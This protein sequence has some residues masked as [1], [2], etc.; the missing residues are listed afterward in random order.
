MALAEPMAFTTGLPMRSRTL[1]AL[2]TISG[3]RGLVTTEAPP[4]EE[5]LQ[6]VRVQIKELL[7]L[8]VGWDSSVA[9]AIS[10]DAVETAINCLALVAEAVGGLR[11]PYVSPTANGGVNIEW[12]DPDAHFD[13][14]VEDGQVHVFA[15]APGV[16]WE[17]A[18]R[19][20][21]T[22]AIGVLFSRF[23]DR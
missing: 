6:E 21:P 9:A 20:I 8:D 2:E 14:T 22:D 19:D 17:G 15:S 7:L 4:A 23:A 18:I 12:H 16:E 13:L 5:W 1:P 3:P 11:R 10:G